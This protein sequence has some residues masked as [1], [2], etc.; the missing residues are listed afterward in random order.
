MFIKFV[1]KGLI[2]SIGLDNGLAPYRRQ[3]IIWTNADLI[4]WRIYAALGGDALTRW[5]RVTHI[6][7]GNLTIIGSDNGLSPGW[8]QAIIWTNAIVNLTLRNKLQWNIF[9]HEN[10]L[11]MSSA[12]LR[13]FCLGLNVFSRKQWWGAYISN[14]IL[15]WIDYFLDTHSI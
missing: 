6:C 1:P 3:A 2:D 4:H 15:G 11:K 7:V 13:P 14:S 10:A 8:R 12:K 9:I 5:G